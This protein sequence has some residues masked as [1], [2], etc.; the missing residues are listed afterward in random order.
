MTSGGSATSGAKGTCMHTRDASLSGIAIALAFAIV[1][2]S[3]SATI[4]NLTTT[5]IDGNPVT[6]TIFSSVTVT[7]GYIDGNNVFFRNPI[8]GFDSSGSG[9]FRKMFKLADNNGGITNNP[10]NGYNRNTTNFPDVQ[11]SSGFDKAPL[12]YSNLATDSS[13]QYF[14]FALDANEVAAGAPN[15]YISLD[16]LRFYRGGTNDPNPLPGISNMN[17][18]G[19][20]VWDMN[21]GD[22][23]NTNFVFIDAT[24]NAGSGN[25]DLFVFV[26]KSLFDGAAANDYIY[27][28][29]SMG[30]YQYMVPGAT[31]MSFQDGFE[32]WAI[33][34][35]GFPIEVVPEP[36]SIAALLLTCGGLFWHARRR[37]AS[38]SRR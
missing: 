4:V 16:D 11:I 9:M 22:G 15:P 35:L 37:R 13:G 8:D 1:P 36:G 7:G 6:T 33:M 20:L 29:A 38:T 3:T 10:E 5:N 19:T 2:L 17:N 32:E 25:S 14:V 27:M 30:E 34:N 28:Y 12:V 23:P 26:K 21:P 24:I 18:L 31:D